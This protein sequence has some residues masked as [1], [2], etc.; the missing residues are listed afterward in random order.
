MTEHPS[1]VKTMALALQV[2]NYATPLEWNCTRRDI[3]DA[4]GI[5]V[6]MVGRVLNYAGWSDRPR[7]EAQDTGAPIGSV[8]TAIDTRL[9]GESVGDYLRTTYGNKSASEEPL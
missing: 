9:N 7:L 8:I 2:Y 1:I 3:A 4:L 5:T 6:N